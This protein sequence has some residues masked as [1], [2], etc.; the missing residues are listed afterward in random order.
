M[1]LHPRRASDVKTALLRLMELDVVEEVQGVRRGTIAYTLNL[2]V[3]ERI[4]DDL[5]TLDD[6]NDE[7]EERS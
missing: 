5:A 2:E 6:I 7:D 4:Y 1:G 3:A